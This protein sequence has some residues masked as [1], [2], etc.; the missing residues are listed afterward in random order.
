M[1]ATLKKTIQAYSGEG[2]WYT[3]ATSFATDYN[4][5]SVLASGQYDLY[6][7]DE[8]GESQGKEWI[9]YK[10]GDGF[11][12][13]TNQGYLYAHNPI[14]TLRMSGTL[15]NG[16]YSPTVNLSYNNSDANLKGWNLLGNPTAH[17][18]SFTKTDEVSDGYYYIDYGDAW[19]YSTEN[20]V[21]VGR[22]F[23]VKANAMG[24]NVTLNPQSKGCRE[25]KGQYLCLSIGEEKAY[26]KLNEGVSM[27]LMDLNGR[28]SNI[29]LMR[30]SK[31]YV[32]L[33]RD[34]SNT[35]DL[36]FEA[37]QEGM[38]TLTVNTQGL[39]LDY[40]HLIDHKTGADVDLLATPSYAF[41]ASED[42]YATRFRLV[43]APMDG[44]ATGSE[45]FAYWADGEICLIAEPQ[46]TATLQVMDLTGR[47]MVCSDVARNVSTTN[48]TP[49]VYV[50][51]LVTDDDVRVQKIVVK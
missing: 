49:G 47:M 7:Y 38:Q 9:N 41:E 45:T 10:Q 8:D 46:G 11:D 19:T 21:P 35:L 14:T 12:L 37:R 18:I 31:P 50:L 2:G 13:V 44:P 42:D 5:A 32:M 36:C 6:A 27:P 24:Q 4:P 20:V 48:M 30:E 23:L 34:D 15:N 51:R 25:E 1:Q 26:V 16:T 29:Y 33:V 28:H 22:G 40:L 3:I 17:N 43:F 39:D